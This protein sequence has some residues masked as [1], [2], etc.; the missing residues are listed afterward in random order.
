[1]GYLCP[2]CAEPFE[3]GP[4]VTNHLAVTAIVHGEDHEAWLERVFDDWA[5]LPRTELAEA[6]S[7]V[8]EPTDADH[9]HPAG[10]HGLLDGNQKRTG[11][12]GRWG[13]E[14]SSAGV[15]AELASLDAAG[16]AILR[17][18]Q[19]LTQAMRATGEPRSHEQPAG[20]DEPDGEHDDDTDDNRT[21]QSDTVTDSK[22]NTESP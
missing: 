6:V 4:A 15:A 12:G 5:S 16:Q 21:E 10:G 22:S 11:E 2:V 3:N 9:D 13:S 7:D 14:I 20:E 17:D 19:A 18:A 1:M 8:A